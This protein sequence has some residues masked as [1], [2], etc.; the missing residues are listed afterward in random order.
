MRDP[1]GGLV[2]KYPKSNDTELKEFA[3]ARKQ[4]GSSIP[5]VGAALAESVRAIVDGRCRGVG[6]RHHF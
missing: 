5:A 6:S 1:A 3:A 4:L 2:L